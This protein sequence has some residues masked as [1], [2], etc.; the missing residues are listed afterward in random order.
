MKT[1]NLVLT[2]LTELANLTI[3]LNSNLESRIVDTLIGIMSSSL[4]LAGTFVVYVV[5][6]ILGVRLFKM[7]SHKH[8]TH[9]P[10]KSP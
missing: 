5:L 2:Y 9:G 8:A 4:V 10:G 1:S 7:V 3:H 6:A